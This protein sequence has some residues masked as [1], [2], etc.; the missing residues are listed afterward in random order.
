MEKGGKDLEEVHEP[1]PLTLRAPAHPP[2][3][4]HISGFPGNVT[5]NNCML[6][7]GEHYRKDRGAG[8]AREW[9][10]VVHRVLRVGPTERA[11]T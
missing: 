2:S 7:S 10:E 1:Q 8:D 9:V 5:W 11:K 3:P 6:F 4:S